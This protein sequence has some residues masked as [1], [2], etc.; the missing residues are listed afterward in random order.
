MRTRVQAPDRPCP[1]RDVRPR[2]AFAAGAAA[3][4]SA[5]ACVITP[6]SVLATE[7]ADY[8]QYA[9][10]IGGTT[11]TLDAR[12]FDAAGDLVY[13]AEQSRGLTI[14][15]RQASGALTYVGGTQ[16]FTALD[17]RVREDFA[18]V[19]AFTDGLITV[20][21]S[22]PTDPTVVALYEVSGYG[23]AVD[24]VDGLVYLGVEHG[25][26]DGELRIYDAAA[27]PW[28]PI[29][30]GRVLT[31]W[32]VRTVRVRP[33]FAYV[34]DTFRL[35][36]APTGG[37]GVYDVSDPTLPY[38]VAYRGLGVSSGLAFSGTFAFVAAETFGFWVIDLSDPTVPIR[39]TYADGYAGEDV[40]VV[41]ETLWVSGD[42]VRLF[43]IS[44]PRLPVAAGRLEVRSGNPGAI[45]AVGDAVLVADGGDVYLAQAG[46][47][48]LAAP[49][50]VVGVPERVSAL[51]TWPGAAIAGDSTGLRVID[52]AT[53]DKPVLRGALDD[54]G[55]ISSLAYGGGC[56]VAG[57]AAGRIALVD[58][59]DLDTPVL[60]DV[61][62]GNGEAIDAL[63]ADADLIAF[64][65]S[66]G[67]T[68]LLALA[69]H[70]G[71]AI[72]PRGTLVLPAPARDVALRG[73]TA[74]VAMHAGGYLLADVSDPAMPIVS[75]TLVTGRPVSLDWWNDRLV[76]A[77]EVLGLVVVDA[78]KRTSP[79]VV[80]QRRLAVPVRRVESEAGVAW[81]GTDGGVFL[82]DLR[83]P[84][85]ISIGFL[86]SED[87]A[88][89]ALGE[90]LL[91]GGATD[92]VDVFAGTCAAV[93]VAG[94]EAPAVSPIRLVAAPNPFLGSTRISFDLVRG[95]RASL[96]IFDVTGRRVRTLIDGARRGAGTHDASWDGRDDADRPV[97]PGTYFY[98]LDGPSG[99]ARG[100]ITR[101]R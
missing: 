1:R 76:V 2:L 96:S 35:E 50:A 24:V 8:T 51:V 91:A 55:P 98:V 3:W 65:T 46:S 17:V 83:G 18:Y 57:D 30:Q 60:R 75:S 90:V 70:D 49:T 33:P 28:L 23:L 13:V 56:V 89:M 87:L 72:T 36:G 66:A 44:N 15:R 67:G 54:V 47:G 69:T 37:I 20:D 74:A 12:A 7:C 5:L 6:G 19:A 59:S 41:G 84:D 38:K 93:G 40:A 64:G 92:H 39:V 77:D 62:P 26:P 45:D 34:I 80:G 11:G 4:L 48:A 86:P 16:P 10:W 32:Q 95:G 25:A 101:V 52:L 81:A 63:A 29:Y 100:T 73:T 21:V 79:I 94:G 85:P 14:W 58:V 42:A 88:A 82:M 61:L 27:N 68:S 9:H 99:R 31:P 97:S 22:D 53:P 43:D 78:A 71:G